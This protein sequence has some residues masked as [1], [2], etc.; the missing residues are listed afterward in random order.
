MRRG[1]TKTKPVLVGAAVLVGALI[2]IG[3]RELMQQ[4]AVSS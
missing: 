1:M 2:A 4:I 3:G